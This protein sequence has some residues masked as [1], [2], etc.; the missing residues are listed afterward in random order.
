MVLSNYW[1][2]SVTFLNKSSIV[3]SWAIHKFQVRKINLD[4]WG[5]KYFSHF[6]AQPNSKKN[7][8]PLWRS[9]RA[10]QGLLWCSRFNAVLS[11]MYIL[12]QRKEPLR[13]FSL[14]YHRKKINFMKNTISSKVIS[15]V[16]LVK[17][18]EDIPVGWC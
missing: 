3:G 6:C 7:F 8:W 17:L 11:N 16:W 15:N 14:L 12:E 2:K 9:M 13:F 1:K 4:S 10:F 18:M 5:M